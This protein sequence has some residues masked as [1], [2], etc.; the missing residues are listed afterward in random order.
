MASLR[1][2]I[3]SGQQKRPGAVTFGD[4]GDD[5]LLSHH[6][7]R[8]LPSSGAH[9]GDGTGSSSSISSIGGGVKLPTKRVA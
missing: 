7:K 8:H 1:E 5:G 3:F 9:G 6:R 4:G 2:L